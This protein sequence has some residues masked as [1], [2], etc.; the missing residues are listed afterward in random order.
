MYKQHIQHIQLVEQITQIRSKQTSLGTKA[1]ILGPDQLKALTDLIPLIASLPSNIA[2][3][4]A[5]TADQLATARIQDT[6]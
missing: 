4:Q 1:G 6:I 5:L 2:Q 3:I